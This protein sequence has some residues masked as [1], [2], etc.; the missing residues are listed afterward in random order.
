MIE[1]GEYSEV[2]MY[3]KPIIIAKAIR[4]KEGEDDE[5]EYEYDEYLIAFGTRDGREVGHWCNGIKDKP[6]PNMPLIEIGSILNHYFGELE[7][8]ENE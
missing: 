3:D 6:Y 1:L 5:E 2:V 7:Y 8:F 4:Y